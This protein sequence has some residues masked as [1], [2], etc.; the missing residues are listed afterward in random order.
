MPGQATQAHVNSP[1][2]IAHIVKPSP[3]FGPPFC[4]AGTMRMRIQI[5][6]AQ[7]AG[8]P[9][10][11]PMSWPWWTARR[12][13][14]CK[15]THPTLSHSPADCKVLLKCRSHRDLNQL[16]VVRQAYAVARNAALRS[17]ICGYTVHKQGQSPELRLLPSLLTCC[18]QRPRHTC[19][20]PGH[21][22][23]M[24]SVSQHAFARYAVVHLRAPS[25][26]LITTQ[27]RWCGC[28]PVGL[29]HVSQTGMYKCCL[30]GRIHW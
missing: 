12:S 9:A 27:F 2:N 1:S 15:V 8:A 3:G 16:L 22:F 14:S 28:S 30:C 10:W 25:G 11:E 29:F 13:S 4:G 20:E 23:E 6:A 19:S 26:A 24:L 17:H 18:L 21:M 7:P 5:P